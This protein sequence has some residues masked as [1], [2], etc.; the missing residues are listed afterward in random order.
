[1]PIN[2]DGAPTL[3]IASAARERSRHRIA[4]YL[5]RLRAGHGW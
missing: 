5:K 4:C 1:L 3:R 2:D